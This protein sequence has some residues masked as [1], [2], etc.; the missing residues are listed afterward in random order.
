MTSLFS[1]H[2]SFRFWTFFS[3]HSLVLPGLSILITPQA[4]SQQLHL[5]LVWSE[6]NLY[7]YFCLSKINEEDYTL[8]SLQGTQNLKCPNRNYPL[9]NQRS[10]W[11]TDIFKGL[12]SMN[13]KLLSEFSRVNKNCI[14]IK[15]GFKGCF[16]LHIHFEKLILLLP[17][18]YILFRCYQELWCDC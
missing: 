3:F 15:I 10:H 4:T 2:F 11:K 8:N 7:R 16:I 14:V 12:F 6:L 1:I 9:R 5:A 13:F 18:Y 17:F